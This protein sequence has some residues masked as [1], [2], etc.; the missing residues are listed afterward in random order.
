MA[1]LAKK[2]RQ[3]ITDVL[4]EMDDDDGLLFQCESDFSYRCKDGPDVRA[5]V[6]AYGGWTVHTC[7]RFFYDPSASDSKRADV[8]IHELLHLYGHLPEVAN[9]DD[10]WNKTPLGITGFVQSVYRPPM[11]GS[12]PTS[13][14][15]AQ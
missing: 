13:T 2:A 4:D 11:Y 15:A 14:G 8:A 12:G 5:W 10:G 3:E 9:P 7:C 6:R 1:D